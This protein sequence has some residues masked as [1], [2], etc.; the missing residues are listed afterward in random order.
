MAA[1]GGAPEQRYVLTTDAG[2][3]FVARLEDLYSN[4]KAGKTVLTVPD[5]AKVLRPARVHDAASDWLAVASS[6]GHVLAFAVADLPAM[7]RGK[8]NKLIA[9]PAGRKGEPKLT[10]AAVACVPAGG[11]LVVHSGKRTLT[12]KPADLE[13]YAGER[14]RRGGLLPR[15]FQRVDAL[16][17]GSA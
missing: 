14:G 16:S 8:G 3:G 9:L 13:R 15:G 17:A 11:S 12:L 1:L 2:Y 4:K 5:D 6:D 10:V 7:E